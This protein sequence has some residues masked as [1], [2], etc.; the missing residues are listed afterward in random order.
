MTT[1]I[2]D[3]NHYSS[4]Q[5]QST[6]L[7]N[8]LSFKSNRL[9]FLEIKS[10]KGS[11][12][13]KLM[14]LGIGS[15]SFRSDKKF[16]FWFYSVKLHKNLFHVVFDSAFMIFLISWNCVKNLLNKVI[17]SRVNW[18]E[19]FLFLFTLIPSNFALLLFSRL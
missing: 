4:M 1:V 3:E 12:N 7:I 6:I 16:K 19:F 11:F 5:N 10:H 2:Q 17:T 18:F 13:H 14:A 9:F 8:S 15:K